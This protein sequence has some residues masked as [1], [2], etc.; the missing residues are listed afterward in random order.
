MQNGNPGKGF[1]WLDGIAKVAS[2][3]QLA[4]GG[5]NRLEG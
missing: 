2:T 3:A 5:L 1:C 4:K